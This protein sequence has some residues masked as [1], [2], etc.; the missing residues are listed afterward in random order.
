MEHQVAQLLTNQELYGWRFNERAAWEL[1]ST[2]RE[3]LQQIEATLC[4]Q[5][6]FVPGAE[7]TPKRDNSTSG[8]VKGAQLT[9]LKDFNPGSRDHI[10][11]ILSNYYQWKPTKLTPTGK[12]IIDEVVLK[13]IGTEVS[14]KFLRLMTIQKQLG[15]LSQGANAWLKLVTNDRIH[16]HCSVATVSHRCAHRSPNLGQVPSDSTFR[17]LFTASPGKVMVGADLSG[18]ELRMLGH[19][20][21][22][23]DG[24]RYC[25]ILL[26]G[27]IHQVNADA[28]GVSRRE[29]KT[30]SYAML[31]GAGALK[32]GL[33]YDDQLSETKAKK[34][35]AEL[36]EAFISA[37]DGYGSLLAAV[38]KAAERGHIKAIDGR[39]IDVASP[40][41][42][43]NALLQSS[44]AVIAKR[45]ML[46]NQETINSTNIAARQLAFIHDELQFDCEQQHAKDLSTSLVFSAAAAG[47][48]YNLRVPIGAEAKIGRDWSE[49]H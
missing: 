7:F 28:M 17:K 12:P 47:E 40:H 20:L 42:A 43:L 22:R 10:A 45:W 49:V 30:I 25:D 19:Y 33:T 32:I 31:Y 14:M 13:E 34:K 39:Q 41:K 2:L 35:G 26:N 44:S 5:F 1:E 37:I 27:D 21:S 4:R 18:I 9:R 29:V 48:Y 3:E 11:F 15:F 38:K 6:P 16:H 46:I 36:Q 24:G 8:Y 23:Y